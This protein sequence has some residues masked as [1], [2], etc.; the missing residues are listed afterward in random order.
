MLYGWHPQGNWINDLKN[1]S[2]SK[3]EEKGPRKWEGFMTNEARRDSKGSTR[4]I[5][6]S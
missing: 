5:P 6:I 3:K 1:L 4:S 2:L